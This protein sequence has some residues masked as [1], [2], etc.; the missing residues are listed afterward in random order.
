MS[1]LSETEFFQLFPENPTSLPATS[2]AYP[3]PHW[4]SGS[5]YSESLT[6]SSFA[7]GWFIQGSDSESSTVP[8]ASDSRDTVWIKDLVE[9]DDS[10]EE[11]VLLLINFLRCNFL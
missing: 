6:K 2:V 1:I 4:P 5:D 9:D 3:K 7:S 8:S 10:D 11:Y